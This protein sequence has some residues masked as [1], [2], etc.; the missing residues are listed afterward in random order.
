[1]VEAANGSDG[2]PAASAAIASSVK[3][4]MATL[5]LMLK[6]L[7]GP[8]RAAAQAALSSSTTALGTLDGPSRDGGGSQKVGVPGAR[9]DR[10]PAGTTAELMAVK[11]DIYA[12]RIGEIKDIVQRLNIARNGRLVRKRRRSDVDLGLGE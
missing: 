10:K 6:D 4:Q 1:V 2:D 5:R 3:D 12:E 7:P 9:S 11:H 8:A